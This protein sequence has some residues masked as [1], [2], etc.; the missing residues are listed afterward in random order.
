MR[1]LIT[2]ASGL[3]GRELARELAMTGAQVIGAFR[4]PNASFPWGDQVR[5]RLPE[6]ACDATDLQQV[7]QGAAPDVVFHLAAQ[8]A[9]DGCEQAPW[10]AWSIN[11]TGTEQV[12]AAATAAG[13]TLVYMSTDYVFDGQSGGYSEAA[14]PAPINWYGRTK[15]RGEEAAL[16]NHPR[17]LVVRSTLYGL[18]PDEHGS[19]GRML[20]R[21][22]AGMPV[23]L[24]AD[25]FF[26]PLPAPVLARCLVALAASGSQGIRHLPGPRCSRFEFGR[27]VA[28]R[29]GLNP[30]LVQ[31]GQHAATDKA[32]AAR[33][34]DT[35]LTTLDPACC[36]GD[37]LAEGL[38]QLP[39][40]G[41]FQGGGVI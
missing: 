25:S 36:G 26:T 30:E 23:Q 15:A 31:P 14:S 1:A 40:Q 11:V 9:V 32:L 34:R 16:A 4:Q 13:A 27:A 33:P 18:H 38:D 17:A 7:V 19:L 35:S 28:R 29:F 8:T 6:H 20:S 24:P 21:L 3:L 41:H 5:L 22:R 10:R 37:S 2:G 39:Q 12:A